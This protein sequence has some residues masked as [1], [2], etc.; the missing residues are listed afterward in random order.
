L[1]TTSHNFNRNGWR[2]L[3]TGNKTM[4]LNQKLKNTGTF[5]NNN[6][7]E[8]QTRSIPNKSGNKS[9]QHIFSDRDYYSSDIRN[10]K[11]EGSTATTNRRVMRVNIEKSKWSATDRR[12]QQTSFNNFKYNNE[13]LKN[14]AQSS[15][16]TTVRNRAVFTQNIA[17][18]S[19]PV[20]PAE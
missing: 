11:Q 17:D 6:L 14:R 8:S 16:F 1:A 5:T 15:H 2:D 13:G 9:V 19:P 4:K 10:F 3:T 12:F 20:S 18:S 7:T